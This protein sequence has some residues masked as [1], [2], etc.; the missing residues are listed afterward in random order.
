MTMYIHL[1]D[2][3]M[4]VRIDGL[5]SRQD[6]SPFIEIEALAATK[7]HLTLISRH[8]KFKTLT[9]VL[10]SFLAQRRI[11]RSSLA[12]LGGKTA[13]IERLSRPKEGTDRPQPRPDIGENVSWGSQEIE[14]R[15][16]EG[17]EI[18]H[19]RRHRALLE[20]LR[21]AGAG[22]RTFGP[23]GNHRLRLDNSLPHGIMKEILDGSEIE[24]VRPSPI[25][26]L[27]KVSQFGRQFP[28]SADHGYGTHRI[29]NS[30][31]QNS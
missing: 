2:C 18:P 1:F 5:I 30:E 13:T 25:L 14:R 22:A 10:T 31:I 4:W 21:R 7:R 23:G 9:T 26:K 28:N 20:G 24:L 19:H 3:F 27:P 15:S 29:P 6:S 16:N 12:G 11:L 8:E 17:G